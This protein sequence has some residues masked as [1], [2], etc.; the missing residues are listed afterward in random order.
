MRLFDISLANLKR[1]KAKASFVLI[2]L[3]VGVTA[4]VAFMSLVDTLTRDINHKLEKYGANIMI[5][6]KTENLSLTYGGMAVGGV[7]FEM[8]EILQEDLGRIKEIKNAANVAAVGP[9]VLGS[10]KVADRNVLLAGVDF[11]VAYILRPWWK[12]KG[13]SPG[14]NGILLGAEASRILGLGQGDALAANGRELMV[15]GVLEP[16]GSQDDQIIFAPL[17]TA[18]EVLGKEGRISMAEVAALCAACP[19]DDMVAQ[20]SGVLPDAK[21]MAIRQVVKGRM[22]TLGHFNKFAYGLSLLV[23]LVGGL[24]VLVTMM[25]SVRERTSEF[26]IFMAIGFR[27]RHVISMVLFE[28]AVISAIAGVV[29]YFMGLGATKLTIPFFTE[30]VDVSLAFDPVLALGV[31]LAAVFLGLISSA[32]P[33]VMAGNLDPNEALRSL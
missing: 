13:K 5:L 33:A 23:M 20:I 27:R 4:V 12:I 32:Y 14:E 11:Q 22:E 26:G 19:I 29:G 10:I 2:G 15:T 16:T 6:P 8:R 3:L 30:S 24:V 17:K 28:A 9:M 25:G 1:R 7:S 21:V 18:Q 31:F